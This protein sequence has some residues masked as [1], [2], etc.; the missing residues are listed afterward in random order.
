M[1]P[2]DRRERG[3]QPRIQIPPEPKLPGQWSSA[4]IR[5]HR[6]PVASGAWPQG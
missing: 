6:L 5:N 3:D 1:C 2:A 4:T